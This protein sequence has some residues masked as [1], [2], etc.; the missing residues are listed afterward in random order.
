MPRTEASTLRAS[1]ERLDRR[2]EEFDR[3]SYGLV[4][5]EPHSLEELRARVG[6]FARSVERHLHDGDA[7]AA[8]AH[9]G[10]AVARRLAAEHG[11]FRSSVRELVGLLEVV[12]RDDH[13]GHRQALGQYGRIFVEALRV[14][15]RDELTLVPGGSQPQLRAA[16]QR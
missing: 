8:P 6:E 10:G 13:G 11:R 1:I 16:G 2:S 9:G 7:S 3:F 14:H 4:R 15:L 12:E 5:L